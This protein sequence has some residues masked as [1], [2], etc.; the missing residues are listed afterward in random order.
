[1]AINAAFPIAIKDG[2]ISH[3][4]AIAFND[5]LKSLDGDYQ[6][7]IRKPKKLRSN[8]QNR[9]A[10]GV[11]FKMIS[12][13]TGMTVNEVKEAMKLTFLTYEVSRMITVRST[14]DL[15]TV[16]FEEFNQKCRMWASQ[17][18]NLYIPLPDEC[19]WLNLDEL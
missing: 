6:L 1:M 13:E 5:Y 18:I 16:E 15:S 10:H 9:Y 2:Q 19:D 3:K 8:Q 17:N 11:I 12:D 7:V 4:K 14:A